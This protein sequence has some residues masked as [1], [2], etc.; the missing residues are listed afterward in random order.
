MQF[1]Q[2]PAT[3]DSPYVSGQQPPTLAER[4]EQRLAAQGGE[5]K[6]FFKN[7][8]ETILPA[9]SN[10]MLPVTAQRDADEGSLR[11]VDPSWRVTP[12]M[13]SAYPPQ[14]WESLKDTTNEA[15]YN[16]V[17][18]NLQQ[19]LD[20]KEQLQKAGAGGMAAAITASILDPV[21]YLPIGGA[22]AWASKGSRLAQAAKMGIVSGGI[23]GAHMEALRA[24]SHTRTVEDSIHGALFAF[25]LG[26]GAKFLFPNIKGMARVGDDVPPTAPA[27]VVIDDPLVGAIAGAE[28][29]AAG[30]ERRIASIEGTEAR[31]LD[32][33]GEVR[34]SG[35]GHAPVPPALGAA[36]SVAVRNA[37]RGLDDVIGEVATEPV[38]IAKQRVVDLE[39]ALQGLKDEVTTRKGAVTAARRSASPVDD[40]AVRAAQEAL[41][42]VKRTT[43]PAGA[44]SD[45]KKAWAAALTEARNGLAA[46]KLSV[47]LAKAD[48]VAAKKTAIEK[49]TADL[50]AAEGNHASKALELDEAKAVAKY[51]TDFYNMEKAERVAAKQ[52]ELASA[53][54]DLAQVKQDI[55]DY[56]AR[57]AA[58]EAEKAAAE[59]RVKDIEGQLEF[60]RTALGRSQWE[61]GTVRQEINRLTD[62]A[63]REALDGV[64]ARLTA[65]ELVGEPLDDLG[66]VASRNADGQLET[67]SYL[68]EAVK[69]LGHEGKKT[70]V[71][72]NRLLSSIGTRLDQSPIQEVRALGR[73]L[74]EMARGGAANRENTAELLKSIYMD[75]FADAFVQPFRQAYKA[76]S[77]REGISTFDKAFFGHGQRKFNGMIQEEAALLENKLPSKWGHVPEVQA[78]L[79]AIKET[80]ET[81][82]AQMRSSGVGDE[83]GRLTS[84]SPYYIP[85]RWQGAQLLHFSNRIG[86]DRVLGMLSEGLRTGYA[87]FPEK[88]ADAIAKAIY[89]RFTERAVDATE[90]V[91]GMFSISRRDELARMLKEQGLDDVDIASVSKRL[92]PEKH[93]GMSNIQDRVPLN[94]TVERG[95]VRL[96]DMLDNNVEHTMMNYIRAASGWSAMARKGIRNQDE[97]DAIIEAARRRV[98]DRNDPAQVKAATEEFERLQ[99]VQ[100]VL[101]GKPPFKDDSITKAMR[102]VGDLTH[103]TALGGMG[104][105]Q[106]AEFGPAIGVMGVM[107][108]LKSVPIL[109]RMRKDLVSGKLKDPLWDDLRKVGTVAGDQ[110]LLYPTRLRDDDYGL[111]LSGSSPFGQFIDNTLARGKEAIGYLSAQYHIMSAQNKMWAEMLVQDLG[112]LAQKGANKASSKRLHDMGLDTDRLNRVV[113]QIK[114]HGEFTDGRTTMLN[115]SK[116]EPQ[117]LEDLQVAIKRSSQQMLQQ[118]TFSELPKWAQTPRGKMISQ[119]RTYT[120][121]AWEKQLQRQGGMFGFDIE[122]ASVLS[123][124]MGLGA[125]SYMAKTYNASLGMSEI[126]RQKYLNERMSDE[127]LV[128]G[129]LSQIGLSSILPDAVGYLGAMATGKNPMSY[130]SSARTGVTR[131]A[132]IEMRDF[133]ASAGYVN[134]VL[135]GV[136][137]GAKAARGETLSPSDVRA[138][139]GL[140]PLNNGIGFAA[141]FNQLEN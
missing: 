112:E 100:D 113:E 83:A 6:G 64:H 54:Q 31:L 140:A 85:R 115:V 27:A 106:L 114:K 9:L 34:A 63:Q 108:T 38:Q 96:M 43:P 57:K 103:I 24:T 72:S 127:A 65:Q 28:S 12:E 33:L 78:A 141:F 131:D 125:M 40:S 10:E 139:R 82:M 41:D 29:R 134:K 8:G 133:A 79:K 3:I 61:L 90:D 119:F 120:I 32:S 73:M 52:Q 30:I 105:T 132:E 137:T 97:W 55:K 130:T 136:A 116:W 69:R 121:G 99:L 14:Y 48:A 42:E 17:T 36:E 101:V 126:K 37:Q 59:A 2:N 58:Y 22:F 19:E 66:V 47:R 75:A 46:S 93:A 1:D 62:R 7:M 26:G 138:L 122:T 25:G 76:W 20:Y 109:F 74:S 88:E 15:H 56:P 13:L 81:I 39:G 84:G 102:R 92:Y 107:R 98:L 111:G 87:K 45:V 128:V 123:W 86:K 89:K 21:N 95:D 70:P 60:A 51:E 50:K 35:P 104:I 49:A 11:F 44:A 53:K 71:M 18:A 110:H 91:G 23:G 94:L 5:D 118:L 135:R 67:G 80:N 16:A 117:A 77:S 124:S 68:D 4:E 129:A